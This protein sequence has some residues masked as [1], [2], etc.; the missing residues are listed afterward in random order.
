MKARCKS[1]DDPTLRRFSALLLVLAFLPAAPGMAAD[2]D[3]EAGTLNPLD[4]GI[5]LALERARRGEVYMMTCA[6]GY[7]ITKSGRHAAARELF[8]ACAEAGYTQAMTW[9]SQLENN[10]LGAPE[11]P[12][13][14]AAWDRRAAEAGDPVGQFNYGLD[15]IRGR[16]VPQDEAAGRARVDEAA[17]GGLAIAGRLQAEGYDLDAVTPDADNWKYAPLY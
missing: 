15:L 12:D 7:Y 3:D 13:A 10:G 8:T 16:G 17:R 2:A 9:M 6:M 5:P 1:D 11:D 14:A 4:S